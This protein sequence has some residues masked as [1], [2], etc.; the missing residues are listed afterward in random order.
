MILR[1]TVGNGSV[2]AKRLIISHKHYHSKSAMLLQQGL[3][4]VMKLHDSH[5]ISIT[6]SEMCVIMCTI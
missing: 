6:L 3:R 1:M 2:M 5:S 4:G